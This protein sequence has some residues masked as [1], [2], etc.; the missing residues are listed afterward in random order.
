MS[1]ENQVE[2]MEDYKEELEASFQQIRRGVEDKDDPEIQAWNTL[3]EY[4]ENKTILQVKI[5]GI[6]NKGVITYVEGIRGFIPAS[7]LS[8]SYVENTEEW[9]NKTVD[10][11]VITADEEEKRLVLSAKEPALEKLAKENQEKASSLSVGTVVEGTVESIQPYGAFVTLENGISGLI[12]ISQISEKR[13][14]S[15]SAVLSIGQTIKAKII[16]IN[17]GKIGLSIKALNDVAEVSKE[18]PSY[19]LPSEEIGTGLGALLKNIKL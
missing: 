4:M 6:V 1:I 8:A 9:L 14:K 5:G 3:R 11:I 13:I 18:E 15:P 19:K 10:A 7:K 12:H 17:N 16:S 2:S